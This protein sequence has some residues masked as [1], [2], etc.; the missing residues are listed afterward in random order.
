MSDVNNP[1]DNLTKKVKIITVGTDK[2]PVRLKTKDAGKVLLLMKN[3]MTEADADRTSDIM[4]RM[5]RLG[6][7]ST[8]VEILD[9][10][11]ADH[12]SDIFIELLVLVGVPRDSL[13]GKMKEL[14]PKKK[15]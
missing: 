13:S 8:D 14:K 5:L 9:D 1:F 7:P 15:V 11:V 12:Y 10:Y 2:V 3:E 6:N 4:L